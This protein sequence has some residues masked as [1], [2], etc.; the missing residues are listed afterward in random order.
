MSRRKQL[1]EDLVESRE[2]P[3]VFINMA[4]SA[5]G[6]TATANRSVVS[7][8][9]KRDQQHL[10]ELRSTADA[11]MAGAHTLATEPITLG[12]GGKKYREA[13]L[14]AGLAEY[15]LRVIVSGSASI[16]PEAEI[17]R[18]HF[19]PV[20]VLTRRNAPQAKVRALRRV[21]DAVE[22]FGEDDIDFHAALGWLRQKWNVTR[23][24]C[25]GGG[26]LNGALFAADLVDE[27][28]V[29]VCPIVF[30]GAHAPTIADGCGVETLAQARMFEFVKCRRVGNEMF[31]T[32]RRKLKNGL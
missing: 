27:L 26:E 17:F 14:R 32:A 10:L 8:G 30:G 28:H 9:S 12:P 21:A 16:S 5:D 2:L 24:L 4:M 15:S 7:F 13:R 11:V 20:I 1:P 3:F 22:A 19:S 25:E 29:T 23:L 31:L 18:H 6:K